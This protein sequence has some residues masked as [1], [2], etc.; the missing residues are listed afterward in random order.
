[1]HCIYMVIAVGIFATD[2]HTA[3]F[4]FDASQFPSVVQLTNTGSGIQAVLGEQ[5][6]P[7][8]NN[9]ATAIYHDGHWRRGEDMRCGSYGCPPQFTQQLKTVADC[10]GSPPC[11]PS[12]CKALPS[13]T[14]SDKEANAF[15]PAI[16]DTA[17][18]EQRIA[19]CVYEPNSDGHGASGAYWFGIG[20]YAG[21]GMTG[22][23]GIGMLSPEQRKP[24]IHRPQELAE[25]S[26]NH[27]E[28]T[29]DTLW[30]GT[31]AEHE[32]IGESPMLGLMQYDW[33]TRKLRPVPGPCG[34]LVLDMLKTPDALWVATDLGLS[35]LDLKAFLDPKK[36]RTERWENYVPDIDHAEIMRPV[37]C[38][39]LYAELLNRLPISMANEPFDDGS[40][41]PF[42]R[43]WDYSSPHYLLYESLRILRPEFLYHYL[44][45]HTRD[46]NREQ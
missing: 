40:R 29:G 36:P 17:E 7:V 23:G 2:A 31:M 24:I 10:S 34:F 22:V 11:S 6:T 32:C 1:M 4:C 16:A 28:K 12:A 38:P 8:T 20:F 14:L 37:Q 19:T 3:A 13:V 15:R 43:T 5:R 45:A 44:S 26:I 35:R 27:I 21:E 25:V 42:P 18:V 46:R 41:Y 39:D 9:P 30:L 33:S